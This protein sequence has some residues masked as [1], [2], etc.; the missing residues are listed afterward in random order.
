MN[1][2][3]KYILIIVCAGF[4]SGLFGQQ[5]PQFTQYM[6]NTLSVNPAYAGSRGH[7]SVLGLYRTQW[8]GLNG[9]PTNQVLTLEGPVGKNVGLGKDHTIFALLDGQVSFT[10]GPGGAP[11][12]NIVPANDDTQ[13][14]AA[15]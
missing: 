13:A 7:L 10:K 14:Q 2:F 15:E 12:V 9:A 4:G 3:C 5:D 1:S 11:I 6:Y 8:V